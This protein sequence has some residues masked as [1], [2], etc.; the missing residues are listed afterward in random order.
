M[1]KDNFL[2]TKWTLS[3]FN[4]LLERNKIFI[5]GTLLLW[6]RSV[7]LC[8]S[9]YFQ[10]ISNIIGMVLLIRQRNVSVK[11]VFLQ[12]KIVVIFY[13]LIF[14][15]F[16]RI[17]CLSLNQQ[18]I[19]D[20]HVLHIILFDYL[21]ISAYKNTFCN[22]FGHCAF[23]FIFCAASQCGI[24]IKCLRKYLHSVIGLWL[25][26]DMKQILFNCTYDIWMFRLYGICIA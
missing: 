9:F 17:I 18:K 25:I 5:Q 7:S 24:S 8:T 13:Y 11:V 3:D 16:C 19:Y 1:H 20:I 22:L 12:I 2:K 15:L 6:M 4:S 21:I 23:C 14:N 26:Y 10:N